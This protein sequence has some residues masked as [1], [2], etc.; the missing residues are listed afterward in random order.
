MLGHVCIMQYPVTEMDETLGALDNESFLK[1]LRMRLFHFKL[2][3]VCMCTGRESAGTVGIWRQR[4]TVCYYL[5]LRVA[6]P[7]RLNAAWRLHAHTY[8]HPYSCRKVKN[9]LVTHTR[10]QTLTPHTA[11]CVSVCV[12]DWWLVSHLGSA[13]AV[14]TWS[15]TGPNQPLLPQRHAL[16]LLLYALCLSLSLSLSP[17]LSCLLHICFLYLS[18]IFSLYSHCHY[19]YIFLHITLPPSLTLFPS[20]IP[21]AF[22][23]FCHSL[24]LLVWFMFLFFHYFSPLIYFSSLFNLQKCSHTGWM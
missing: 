18:P 14:Q 16:S 9:G 15:P 12:G 13:T 4:W 20:F 11:W 6:G 1:N 17:S 3:C 21:T 5:L 23:Y 7:K 8:T 24:S 10:A 2:V 19:F 22:G